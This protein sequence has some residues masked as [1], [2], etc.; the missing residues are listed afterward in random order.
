MFR[1]SVVRKLGLVA[2]VALILI[3]GTLFAQQD[4]LGEESPL[5]GGEIPTGPPEPCGC[6][7]CCTSQSGGCDECQECEDLVCDIDPFC[8]ESQWDD[9]CSNLDIMD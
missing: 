3:G 2:V 5:L 7:N 4:D 8:C 6:C 9:L 1:L